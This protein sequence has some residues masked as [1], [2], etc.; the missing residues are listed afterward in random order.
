M[1]ADAGMRPQR[2]KFGPP[3]AGTPMLARRLTTILPGI[4]L[5]DVYD[6]YPPAPMSRLAH[7]CVALHTCSSSG[8]ANDDPHKPGC[9]APLW[10]TLTMVL[11]PTCLSL[12]DVSLESPR[13]HR[14]PFARHHSCPVTCN[15]LLEHGRERRCA[16]EHLGGVACCV[17]DAHGRGQGHHFGAPVARAKWSRVSR[18]IRLMRSDT[19]I[20]VGR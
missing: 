19:M 8:M 15:A 13:F 1:K 7:R 4:P 17:P 16:V 12:I 10:L 18:F 20:S 5:A 9:Y 2:A 11:R 3:G 14:S 6:F